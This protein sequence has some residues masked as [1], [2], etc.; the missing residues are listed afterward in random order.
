V[1]QSKIHDKY[2]PCLGTAGRELFAMF[3]ARIYF[4]IPGCKIGEFSTIKILNGSAFITFR[5]YFL[6]KLE[7]CFIV[8]AYTFDNVKGQ[9][10]IGFKIWNTEKKEKFLEISADI[11]DDNN[12]YL[13]SKTFTVCNKGQFINTWITSTKREAK[14]YIGFLAGTN[15]NDFQQNQIVY[16]LNKREQMAN[17]RGIEISEYNLIEVSIYF[18]ARHCFEHTWI[19]HNDQFLNPN[20]GY[21]S[22]TE[23]QNDCLIYTLFH[24]KNNIQSQYGNANCVNHWIPFTEKQVGAKEKFESAFMSGFLKD[25][26]FSMEA[27]AV[28]NA[29]LELWKYYHEKTKINNTV[30]VNASLYDIKEFFQGRNDKGNM[31]PASTDECYNQKLDKLKD[32]LKTLTVKITPKI[33]EYGFL[34]E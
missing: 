30:S 28:Y 14:T 13:S 16:I 6:A 25:R 5:E 8:P 9:F 26:A 34:K 27:Q 29:G 12:N 1:N 20:D 11:Y 7:K 10:P 24:G 19:N 21:K 18:T 4:E 2:T 3:L 31:N 15:G 33:Y 32:S 23:F 17:P 22:D